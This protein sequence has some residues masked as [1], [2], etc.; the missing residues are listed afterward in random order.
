MNW[1]AGGFGGLVPAGVVTTTSTDPEPGGERAVI[2]VELST[3][4]EG[5]TMS[6]KLTVVAPVKSAPVIVTLVPPLTVPVD[7]LTP[8][9]VGATGG[10]AA[11]IAVTVVWR[12]L[13]GE[14]LLTCELHSWSLRAP[15]ASVGSEENTETS[16]GVSTS[17]PPPSTLPPC[18]QTAPTT[19][20]VAWVTTTRFAGSE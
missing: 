18:P 10:A 3:V 19:E 15:F 9:T 17:K 13:V 11:Q 4:N 8:V 2:W 1:S 14:T 20:N 16:S 5:A 7:G 6:P 12:S